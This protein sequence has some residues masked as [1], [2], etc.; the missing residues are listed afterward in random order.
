M[1][2]FEPEPS[3]RHRPEGPTPGRKGRVDLP[4]PFRGGRPG[5][6]VLR[7]EQRAGGNAAVLERMENEWKASTRL[8]VEIQD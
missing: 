6:H 4:L 1:R 8:L 7:V 3:P 2:C 5:A